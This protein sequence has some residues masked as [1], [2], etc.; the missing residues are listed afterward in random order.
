MIVQGIV[1]I[2]TS[3]P[4]AGAALDLSAN[5]SS[6]Y[7]P[8]G[9]TGTRPTGYN[10]MVRYNTTTPAVE[11]YV[12][13]AW[14]NLL[15]SATGAGSSTLYIGSSLTAANPSIYSDATSGL[16][17][18]SGSTVS[19]ITG[20]VQRLTV[21]PLGSVGIGSTVPVNT[22]DINGA[23]DFQSWIAVGT[24]A[25]A[26]TSASNPILTVNGN[27]DITNG[28]SLVFF[29]GGVRNYWTPSGWQGNSGSVE[30]MSFTN[31]GGIVIGIGTS[32]MSSSNSLEV[33]GATAIGYTNIAAPT[34]GL[35]VKGIVGIGTSSPNAGAALDLS[36]NTSSLYLPTGTT[37]TRPTGYNGMVRYNTTT[38][39][40]EAYVSNAWTSLLTSATGAGSSTLYIGSSLTAAN[41]SIYGDATSGLY[42]PSGSTVSI[43]TGGAQRLTVSPIGSVGIGTIT[44]TQALTVSGN[45]TFS[46]N[47]SVGTNLPQTIIEGEYDL[48]S[49]TENWLLTLKNNNIETN[50]PTAGLIFDVGDSN[51][52]KAG[53]IFQRTAS[54]GR[55][56]I[57]FLN[58]N[59]NSTN[60]PTIAANTRL[61]IKS[62]GNIGIGTTTPQ[63]SLDI[64]GAVA[65]GT[66]YAGI[67]PAP[68]NGMIIQGI[69]GIGTN[70]PNAGAALDL[71]ANTSSLYLPLGTTGT[72]PTG[73]NGMM[74]YNLTNGKFEGYQSNAWQDILTSATGNLIYIG[75]SLTQAN[76]SIAGDAKSGL[77]TP[78]GSTVSIITGGVEALRVTPIGSVGIGT[79]S[80]SGELNVYGS[81][82]SGYAPGLINI[83]ATNVSAPYSNMLTTYVPNLATTDNVNWLLGQGA[84][85]NNAVNLSFNYAGGSGVSSNFFGIGFYNE[86]TALV[87]TAA[88]NVGIGST[89]PLVSLDL[90]QKTDALSL[91]IGTTGTRP[92]GYNGMVRYNSTTPAVEAYVSNAWTN[93]LTSATGAGSSTLYI[94]S[95]LTAANPSIYGDA[96]SGLYTPSSSTVSIITGGT[97]RLTVGTQGYVGIGTTSPAAKLDVY[98]SAGIGAIDLGGVNGISYPSTDSTVGGSIAIG[99]GALLEEPLQGSAAYSNTAIGYQAMGSSGMTTASSDVA[100]GFQAGLNTKTGNNN[101]F[102]GY[103]AMG[104][105]VGNEGSNVVIG[106]NATMSV[107]GSGGSTTII[108]AGATCCAGGTGGTVIGVSASGNNNGGISINGN[109]N[110]NNSIAIGGTTSGASAIAL[111]SGAKNYGSYG[112]TFGSGAGSANVTGTANVI[113]GPSVASTTL[114]S[115]SN[116]ILIGTGSGVDTPATSTSNFLNIGNLIYGTGIGT[117]ASPGNVGIGST[118]PLVSLDISQKTD[119]LSLPIGTTGTRPTGYNGMVRYNST[120]PAVEAYVSNAWTNLLTSAT[121]AGSSTLYIGSSMTAANPS[122][123]GDATSGLYTPSSST[124]SIITGGAQRLTVGSSGNVGIGTT[125]PSAPLS[126]VYSNNG[127]AGG[128]TIQNTNTGTSAISQMQLLNQNGYN[129]GFA[130]YA[131]NYAQGSVAGKAVM[132]SNTG[133]AFEA[134]NAVA[135]GS[136]NIDFIIGDSTNPFMRITGAGNVG[137]GTTTPKSALDVAGGHSVGA[138]YAG[139]TAAPT[140][141]MIVQGIVGIGTSSP[142]T[143]A[144]LD[145]SNNTSSL[146]FPLGTTGTRPTGYNG[147]MRYNLTNGK[148]EGYQSNAWQDILTSATGNLIYIGSSLT[149]ANP[150]I[151]GD[152][153]SG[154]YTP[155][156]S[157]VSI[158]TGGTQRLTVGSTGYVG[159]GT[160]APNALLNIWGSG[161]DVQVNATGNQLAF[162][163]NGY[164]YLTA[165]GASATLQIQAS[166]ASGTLTFGTAGSERLRIGSTGLVGI[167]STSPLVSLDLSQKTDALSLPIGT[168]GTRPTGYN[169]MV[170]YNSTTPAVEA[171]VSNAWTNLLTSATGAG[172]STLYIGSSLTAANPSIYGDATSGL[173]TPSG[174]TV[175]IITGGVEA[176]RVTPIGSVG[177]GTTSPTAPLEVFSGSTIGTT[178]SIINTS[179]SG[180]AISGNSTDS[181]ILAT[182]IL[183]TASSGTGVAGLTTSGN[184]VTG[185]ASG[186]NGYGV[187]GSAAASTGI[188][189]YGYNSAA[190]GASISIKGEV[191]SSSGVAILGQSDATSGGSPIGVEG[192]ATTTNIGYGVVGKELATS[193]VGYAGYF[194]NSGTSGINYGLYV[195]DSSA[196]GWDIYSA[197]IAPNYFASSVGIGSTSPRVSLDMSQQTDAILMPIGTTGT[198]PAT[199]INGMMRYNATNATVETY[200]NNVWNQIATGS[201]ATVFIGSTLSA[202]NPQISGDTTS[203]LYTPSGST[204]S[205]ITSGTQRLTVGSTGNVGIGSASPRAILD[206]SQSANAI[207]LPQGPTEPTAITGMIR[208]NT[209]TAGFEGYDGT[210]WEDFGGATDTFLA[211]SVTAPGLAVETNT[212]TGL[213]QAT[214]NTLSVSAGGKESFRFL[215]GSGTVVNYLTATG[216]A[217]GSGPILAAAGSDTNINLNLTP[218]GTG[219]TAV[220]TGNLLTSAGYIGVNTSSVTAGT[221]LDLSAN[222]TS[223]N[224][225]LL[226]PLGTTGTRPTGVNGMVRYNSTTPAVEAYVS[227]TWTSLL[228]SATGVG[229]STLYIGSSLTAANPSIYGDATSGLYTPSGST[230]SIITGGTPRLTVVP[231]GSVGIGTTSPLALLSLMEPVA[232]GSGGILIQGPSGGG[233]SLRLWT[234]GS[235]PRISGNLAETAN[236]YVNGGGTGFFG[237]G[238]TNALSTLSVSGGVAI[239]TSYA[240]TNAAGSNNLIVQGNVGIGTTTPKSALDVAGGHSV[241]A[242][243]AGITAAPTNGMIVQG[244]VGIGTSSP[245]TGAALDLSANTTTANSTLVL[246]VGTTGTRPITG[247]NGM[248]RYNSTTP[249]IEGYIGN[250]WLALGTAGASGG[251]SNIGSSLTAANPQITG[252]ATSGLYTPLGSTVSIIT[253]GVERLRVDNAG[254]VGIGTMA[255]Q[256]EFTISTNSTGTPSM[257]AIYN[258]STNDAS[259]QGISFRTDTSGAGATTFVETADILVRNEIHNNS[260]MGSSMRFYTSYNNAEVERIRIGS[261][262]FL[263]ITSATQ[264]LQ[265][266]GTNALSFPSDYNSNAS[267]AIG[268]GA[269]A[270]QTIGTAGLGTQGNIAI[271]Y[272][273]MGSAGLLATGIQN[274]AV[275]Y[276][277]LTGETSGIQNTA[278]GYQALTNNSTGNY[279]SAFGE[280][281]L[282]TNQSGGNNIAMGLGAMYL[283]NSG[284]NNVAVGVNA[285]YSN[286]SGGSNTSIGYAALSGNQTGSNNTVIGYLVSSTTLTTG[287]SNILIGTSNSTDVPSSSTSNWLNIGNTIYGDLANHRLAIGSSLTA[288]NGGT[289]LDLSSNTTSGNSSLILP[290]GTTGTRPTGINGM[291]RYNST[292]PAVE[293]YVGNAWGSL[294]MVGGSLGSST[295][296]IG[297]SLTAANPQITGDATSGLYTPLG[298][299][300]SI[301]TGGTQRLT[302]TPIGSVGIG[303][304]SPSGTLQVA[305]GTASGT[306]GYGLEVAAPSGAT[307]NYAAYFNGGNVG[308]GWSHPAAILHINNGGT[309]GTVFFGTD[310]TSNANAVRLSVS[311]G[312]AGTGTADFGADYYGTGSNTSVTISTRNGGAA[313]AERMRITNTGSVGIGSTSPLVSLDL[314]QKTDALSLPIGTTGTRPTGY[315]GMVRYNSTTPAVEAYISNT[316]TA[317][318]TAGASGGTTNIGTSLTAANPQITGD[319]TSGLYTPAG[320]TVSIITGG[321]PR[322]TVVPLGS[323]GI[324]TTAPSQALS[325]IGSSTITGTLSV[326]TAATTGITPDFLIGAST[327]TDGALYHILN[328][329]SSDLLFYSNTNIGAYG[330]AGT[331]YGSGLPTGVNGVLG[332]YWGGMAIQVNST[333]QPTA[334]AFSV[335]VGNSTANYGIGYTP[336][337]VTKNNIVTTYYNKLD[338]GSGGAYFVGPV[339]IGTTTPQSKMDIAGN[340]TIGAT[341]AGV[342]SAPTNGLIV[343]GNVGI[344]TSS[345]NAG[346]ALDLSANTSSLYLPTGTTGTRPTGVNG[347]VRYNST[348]PAVEAYVSN[349]WTS[350]LT[351]AT[352]VGSSTLYIGS[353]LTA[354]NPSIYGDAT[355]GLYT[356]SS[357]TVSIITGGTQRLTVT[358]I[359][360]V[361]IGSTSP[362]T[363]LDIVATTSNY[364]AT[365]VINPSGNLLLQVFDDSSNNG[366]LRLYNSSQTE[367]IRLNTSGSTY[368]NGGNVGIGTSSPNAGA[369]LDLSANTSSLYL[370]TGTTGTRPTG[371]NG[372]VRYNST[373]PAVEA[374]ISN[375]WTALGTAG[376]SGGTTNIGTSLTAANPQITGDATSGLYT[377]AGSTVSIITGGSQR[378]TVGSTGNV[379]IGSSAPL[380][381]LDVNGYARLAMNSSQPVAC[382]AA[383][384]GA[385]AL[386][387]LA[388]TCLCAPA[389]NTW[390]DMVTGGACAW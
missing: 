23:A 224:S 179:Y 202:A 137:I 18:P 321:T 284:N 244:V 43:I 201:L 145:L 45:G 192:T 242:G 103:K 264:G 350:L 271:G 191:K 194:V 384:T 166:G 240:G 312:G 248:M 234:D 181:D 124:V 310:S 64:Y 34:N 116:N 61:V 324:G 180:T 185:S 378:V 1:G 200:A 236:I 249:A 102:I 142:N 141:G 362:A 335:I 96:T 60:G 359:G 308:I 117:A 286:A 235:N 30:Q 48:N 223:S 178:V 282:Y 88:N 41:P 138:G 71:S 375:T 349:T 327:T 297:S 233:S 17:T 216:A 307:N 37:G 14:T 21:V 215:Q 50:T 230:V 328:G 292:T 97:Q 342:N 254:N 302:V 259:G 247:I 290:V 98:T 70:A 10:G 167:G 69:V 277:A 281:A 331:L 295:I 72:R 358:P 32:S 354:A 104:Q 127:Y 266:N 101:V 46:G 86:P 47:I 74:R 278:L 288:I 118:S 159:I 28:N 99:N 115:G 303:T 386:T 13:N 220:T 296:T 245:A 276:Q 29:S 381:T 164:N 251:T 36:A 225:S 79:T 336:F 87:V 56:D 366:W 84:T 125:S 131:N 313:L 285:Q 148:F 221:A 228:T 340:L 3:S 355:S 73:Y 170:R 62:S 128:F 346:A 4:N 305:S 332:G 208:F 287:S 344:G 92:T 209:A 320:S 121:G 357:S 140:N 314:S 361:G 388:R 260:T 154:L 197:G 78:A 205:I 42:T 182:G 387:H 203:G 110:G 94:G 263:N 229:S 196:N 257:L 135:T 75:S 377:P 373:T 274:T 333:S 31:T 301:I 63:N 270:Y 111:G 59:Y 272:Q 68:T 195:S 334:S 106:A 119:A 226:L 2:G 300:V 55:G 176:L 379:G 175:S 9:T 156:S 66:S 129:A 207:I 367:A 204:V 239:G 11:A 343:Q 383:N 157:T 165:S 65:I 24:T 152:A 38:P 90:S 364:S 237:I 5:T 190:S 123:Y 193:N 22:L 243:Y 273:A 256:R 184:G 187:Q 114:G 108:G 33:N 130:Y 268:A 161:G 100:I 238:L 341:Y 289:A 20:G 19:I 372:M 80:P 322:L 173:Y 253:G 109:Q 16:Y 177:I 189:I 280:G 293:A 232:T 227:N 315:N 12:S 122:I 93:L 95:S 171:Y 351:S 329:S 279:N 385:I 188:A 136:D 44:P 352:G 252:D 294:M 210:Y 213:F 139:I 58:S 374:Y 261:T 133:I 169:G 147:M 356:P 241:G 368:F 323:V 6:L 219:N 132:Y 199:P 76:P 298:S 326:N 112:L 67:T 105:T 265:L 107:G 143:G 217:T 390:S 347:M 39:A 49:S 370:P 126:V 309:G 82:G 330:L 163:N 7:L 267:I 353:S 83:T 222:T 218:K 77:Y 146:Y 306:Y 382:T 338:N 318:G 299:T 183:G 275:G 186:S 255:P 15:T 35:L 81:A 311:D 144:A 348:T 89:S 53:I 168:T 160:A 369:A 269:L 26:E 317:L 304:A 371:Y 57:Y 246:P 291:V 54:Y 120:T 339:G 231:L 172:S 51:S 211:G 337:S 174:S 155:S 363:R 360:S 283:N 250:S 345:P 206:I 198:R 85:T 91:P 134:D 8:T 150:S 319:A 27:L 376:A 380:A 40:V 25:K 162:S 262:G 113:V 325:V 151:N 365:Q 149:Q 52:Q 258:N 158:I 153:T 316:W 214:T 212:S 389:T